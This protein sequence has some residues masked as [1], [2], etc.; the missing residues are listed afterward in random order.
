MLKRMKRLAISA[1]GFLPQ[2]TRNSLFHFAYACAPE[3]FARFSFLYS[4]GQEQC[5]RQLASNGFQARTIVD[6]GAYRGDWARMA[7]AIWP[8]A[9][10]VMIEPNREQTRRLNALAAEL[11]GTL[12]CEL[13]GPVD[14]QE[15]AFHVMAT[16]SS[17]LP[18]RSD[19]PR[20]MEI[21][22]LATLDTL[23]ADYL[24]VDLL[25][26]DA[27]GYE[28][29]I[30]DGAAKVLPKV[31]VVLLEAALLEVNE[32]SPLLHDVIQYMNNRGFVAYDVLEMHRR[33]LDRALC[34][35]D[36]IFCRHDAAIRANKRFC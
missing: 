6:V 1:A 24:R 32:G 8:D 23:L 35:I 16:G 28:L 21:R 27:Q 30:L 11:H 25:K 10:I 26:I 20:R 3:E 14:G 12:Y 13:L 18:E 29:S 7:H 9:A 17:V 19:V 5:L 22:N 4:A 34:Q 2:G 36:I 33:P 15:V 31:Q